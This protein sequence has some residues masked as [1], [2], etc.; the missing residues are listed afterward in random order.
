VTRA[1]A[2]TKP[3]SA[4]ALAV[5]IGA[6]LL[7]PVA[8]ATRALDTL[9][10]WGIVQ[11]LATGAIATGLVSWPWRA[12]RRV[13][14]TRVGLAVWLV[15]LV[16]RIAL[17]GSTPGAR[18]TTL[19][20]DDGARWA[21]RLFEER[22]ASILGARLLNDTGRMQAREFPTLPAL[23]VDGYD[24][25]DDEAPRIGSPVVET[26]AQ[27]ESRDAFDCFVIESAADASPDEARGT[28][29]F[30]HGYAGNFAFQCWEVASAARTAGFRTLCPST[31]AEGRWWLPLGED[32][33]RETI[34]HA[35]EATSDERPVVLAG[36][37]NGA[38]GASRL[39]PRLRGMI[40]GLVLISGASP[41]ARD[42]GVPVLVIQ[43]DHD[44][45]TPASLARAY[46]DEHRGRV[47]ELAVLDGTHFVLLE[48]RDEVRRRIAHFLE[49]RL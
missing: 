4:R 7:V 49:G 34:E 20:A 39:A 9:S 21:N 8:V 3:R 1:N 13:G 37:S 45:M 33:A 10:V 41:D 26:Y 5:L 42:P 16:L 32:I 36:L 11:W 12:P 28:V 30:L 44:T 2:K 31:T 17:V 6:L 47:V 40:D 38:M 19:P 27:H 46:R 15:V 35:R 14:P 23:L 22:D 24:R 29:V 43:G 18:L 25:L 48:Q